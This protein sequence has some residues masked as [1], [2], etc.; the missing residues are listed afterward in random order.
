MLG[1]CAAACAATPHPTASTA[2]APMGAT[3]TMAGTPDMV[4]EALISEMSERQYV[5]TDRT[6]NT[7]A[8][9]RPIDNAA[10]WNGLGGSADALPHARV[11]M[12]MMPKGG[13]TS[14]TA[15]MIV[16]TPTADGTQMQV[17]DTQL[18]GIDPRMGLILDGA[19][20]TVM[21][22]AAAMTQMASASEH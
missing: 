22:Q 8:F 6:A 13:A 4:A 17:A 19:T 1:L 16:M 5:L 18:S 2:N 11:I 9:D 7:L 14:V 10:L 12:T 3:R 20:N 15:D 21:A